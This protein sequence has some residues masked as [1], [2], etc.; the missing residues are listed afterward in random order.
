MIK[1]AWPLCPCEG[2]PLN[3]EL[4]STTMRLLLVVLLSCTAQVHAL[5]VHNR[6]YP[7]VKAESRG[8]LQ[9]ATSTIIPQ[10]SRLNSVIERGGNDSGSSASS[11]DTSR[12]ITW[13][14]AVK[15]SVWVREDAERR[16][17]KE[18]IA[19]LS[20]QLNTRC[21]LLLSRLCLNDV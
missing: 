16:T 2:V 12:R 4:S 21:C 14:A 19:W 7:I 13:S 15:S 11:A 3:E 1:G 10:R 8:M 9:G 17:V 5:V 18:Y 20:R 6:A